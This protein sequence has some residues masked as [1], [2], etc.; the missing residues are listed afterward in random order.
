MRIA[1]FFIGVLAMASLAALPQKH[2][3]RPMHPKMSGLD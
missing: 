1:E 2:S 3:R